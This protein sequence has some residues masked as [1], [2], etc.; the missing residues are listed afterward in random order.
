MAAARSQNEHGGEERERD[1]DETHGNCPEIA[2]EDEEHQPHERRGHEQRPAE[3][4]RGV[5]DEARLPEQVGVE[6]DVCRQPACDRREC[7]LDLPRHLE[8][9]DA[10]LLGHQQ[11]H[12][13]LTVDDRISDGHRRTV[14]H[15]GHRLDGDGDA[16]VRGEHGAGDLA[17]IVDAPVEPP[18]QPLPG[19]VE[20]AGPGC[21]VRTGGRGDQVVERDAGSP[22]PLG[23][24]RDPELP[25]LATID[26]D[27]GHARHGEQAGADRPVRQIAQLHR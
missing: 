12:P 23:S 18:E 11:D 7:A 17:G 13:R 10:G 2:E 16:V 19:S 20:K 25:H 24:R 5:L 8:H 27:V 15:V 3:V 22:Q 9:V 4:R 6:P 21:G 26:D 14:R 1:G